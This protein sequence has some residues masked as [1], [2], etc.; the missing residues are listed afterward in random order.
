MEKRARKV[1]GSHYETEV[2][3]ALAECFQEDS[4]DGALLMVNKQR[5]MYLVD[6]RGCAETF[7][8]EH[9]FWAIGC[10]DQ[11]VMGYLSRIVNNEQ[12]P[13]VPDDAVA[14]I[15]MAARYDAGIDD[16]VKVV[17]LGQ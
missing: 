1:I 8:Q 4:E 15:K 16:R 5:D 6:A 12:R 11:F 10:A 2:I 13:V 9:L 3:D 17:W 7:E 14:A